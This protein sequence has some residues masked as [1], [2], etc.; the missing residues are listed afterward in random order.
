MTLAEEEGAWPLWNMNGGYWD[1]GYE[2]LC[3]GLLSNFHMIY[4]LLLRLCHNPGCPHRCVCLGCDLGAA[5]CNSLIVSIARF[6][7]TW[8]T[9]RTIRFLLT[10]TIV[11]G[12]SV[13]GSC[14]PTLFEFIRTW[15]GWSSRKASRRSDWER[16]QVATII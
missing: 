12:G 3:L 9:K 8:L 1:N 15:R 5:L 2:T 11:I 10:T 6:S 16:S 14:H 7:E 4:K 13:L